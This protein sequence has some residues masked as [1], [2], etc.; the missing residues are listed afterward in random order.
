MTSLWGKKKQKTVPPRKNQ[1]ST[2]SDVG[3][4]QSFKFLKET[5]KMR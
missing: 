4:G 5:E 3:K 2:S 1:E